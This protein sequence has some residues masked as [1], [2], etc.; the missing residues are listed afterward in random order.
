MTSDWQSKMAVAADVWRRIF[1]F[2][3]ATH[4][5]RDSVLQRFGFT[6]GDSKALMFLDADEGRTMRSL[7]EAWTCDASNATWMIDRLEQRGLVERRPV[8]GD[9]RVKK[10]VLTPLGVE[11]KAALLEA[12][13]EP[14]QELLELPLAELEALRDAL[15]KLPVR[16]AHEHPAA[17][18]P[19]RT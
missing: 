10:V 4:V 19:R 17:T 11:T 12:L 6:P 15:E 2:I 9:R 14:P 8:A 5:Q 3:I 16:A 1:D 13:Y 7:A 18:N